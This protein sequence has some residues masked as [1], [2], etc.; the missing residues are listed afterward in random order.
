[1]SIST[2]PALPP[3]NVSVDNITYT[4]IILSWSEVPAIY[5]NGIIIE[6]EVEYTQN[7]FDTV[8]TTQNI[9]VT[10]TS[11][12]LTDLEEYVVYFIRVRA[13]TNIG[14]GP[15]SDPVNE[16]T[17]QDSKYSYNV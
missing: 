13:Y 1:M 10:N 5:Q 12:T 17:L 3:Q 9:T 14:S 2:V 4:T 15:Y 11:V 6:Y 7:T 8:P 16:T